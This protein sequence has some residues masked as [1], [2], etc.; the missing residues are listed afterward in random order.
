MV[1]ADHDSEPA[2]LQRVDHHR[3]ALKPIT[4]DRIG[5]G[6]DALTFEEKQVLEDL[7]GVEM[8][9]WGYTIST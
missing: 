6:H 2:D 1:Q 9:E 3:R 7:I 4:E 5:V 8:R